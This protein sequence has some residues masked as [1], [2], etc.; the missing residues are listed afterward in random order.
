M[1][2]NSRNECLQKI[3]IVI[4]INGCLELKPKTPRK[5]ISKALNI[6]ENIVKKGHN[7]Q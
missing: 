3:F 7:T 2:K 4:K 6:Y 1:T 5:V